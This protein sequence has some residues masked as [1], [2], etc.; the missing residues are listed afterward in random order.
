[1]AQRVTC[2]RIDGL[3]AATRIFHLWSTRVGGLHASALDEVDVGAAG[4]VLRQAP[5]H[6]KVVG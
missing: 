1:M 5:T 4:V 2:L 6:E 3:A